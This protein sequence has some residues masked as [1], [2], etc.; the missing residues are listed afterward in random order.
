[1]GKA[2]TAS[3]AFLGR[4]SPKKEIVRS[5]TAY[6]SISYADRSRH[7]FMKISFIILGKTAPL[8]GLRLSASTFVVNLA[9]Y[10]RLSGAFLPPH[11]SEAWP[12]ND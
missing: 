10:K 2:E 6:L 4:F 5:E 8:G 11:S 7:T 12:K 9:D 1:M 3:L